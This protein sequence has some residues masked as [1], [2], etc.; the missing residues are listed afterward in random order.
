MYSVRERS[1][2]WLGAR[3]F[4]EAGLVDGCDLKRKTNYFLLPMLY[5][6]ISIYIWAVI[7]C[8]AN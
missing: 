5:S 1:G 3:D 4:S 7:W 2:S 8:E 6:Q